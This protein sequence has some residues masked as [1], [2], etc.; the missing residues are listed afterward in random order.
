MREVL[1]TI[2][3]TMTYRT[4]S[5]YFIT[6][7]IT[8]LPYYDVIS[9][10]FTPQIQQNTLKMNKCIYPANSSMKDKNQLIL[11]LEVCICWIPS[12]GN[13]FGL[14]SHRKM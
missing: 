7:T 14:L 5:I 9:H 1:N 10:T 8:N 6:F 2:I 11:N 12:S 3:N 4:Y 13:S